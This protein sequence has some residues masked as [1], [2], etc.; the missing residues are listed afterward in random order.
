MR[1]LIVSQYF[2]PETFII[3]DVV[4]NLAL[5]G[6]EVVVAT[7]KPNYPSG[8]I[9]AGYRRY[10]VERETF[11]SRVEVV[12]VPLRPRG[13]ADRIALSRN[14]LSFVFQGL[15][16]FLFL[17]RDRPFDAILVFC[18]SPITAAIPAVA[19]KWQKR[20]HLALWIQDLWP[21]S[22]RTTGFIRNRFLLGGIGVMV[23]AIYAA[24]DTL[25]VQSKAFGPLVARYA[26]ANKIAYLP[27]FAP[28]LWSEAA[29]PLPPALSKDL[30]GCFCAVF[31][32]NLG[33]A[34]GLETVVEAARRLRDRPD[35]RFVIAG[36]GSEAEWLQQAVAEAKLN[37]VVLTG[38]LE[39]DIMPA[40]FARADA[41]LVSL[42][43]DPALDAT[44]PSKVQAYMKAGRPLIGAVNGECARLI[45]QS[46]SGPTVPAGDGSGLA[47]SILA[48]EQ[49]PVS[50]RTRL[51]EAA[52]V[53]F[54][55][56]FEGN[57]I[58]ERMVDVLQTRIANG[59]R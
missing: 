3:N 47:A 58:V 43:D 10:G 30:E 53:F 37:N 22:L 46:G 14:Y 39:T 7:G 19:L 27:N 32:G 54:E 41:L 48:L 57:Q 13:K 38:W 52:R 20:A 23:R 16:H 9:A 36:D 45:A 1:I 40:L 6:H 55:A 31:A 11:E 42:R 26:D 4:R 5:A 49:M 21:E 18:V 29:H 2:W 50:E 24:A 56:H 8:R 17:L 28:D 15:L 12:R 51:G 35:I 25:F 34:Q 59:S 33:K 44:V